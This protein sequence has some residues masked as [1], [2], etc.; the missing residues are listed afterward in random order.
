MTRAE[1]AVAVRRAIEKGATTYNSG[2]YQGSF[3]IYVAAAKS[4]IDSGSPGAQ[5]LNQAIQQSRYQAAD[6]GAWTMRLAYDKLLRD[7]TPVLP[8]PAFVYAVAPKLKSCSYNGVNTQHGRQY[9]GPTHVCTC[10][11]GSW[12]NC[13]PTRV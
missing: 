8:V 4:I 12:I 3:D 10:N 5:E 7:F 11:D 1:V 9:Y 6:Q 2:N 13:I